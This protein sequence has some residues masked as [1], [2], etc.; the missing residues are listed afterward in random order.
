[1]YPVTPHQTSTTQQQV[2]RLC[3]DSSVARHH[4]LTAGRS[5]TAFCMCSS[6][7]SSVSSRFMPEALSMTTRTLHKDT[8][9]IKPCLLLIPQPRCVS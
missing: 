9:A 1:M 5:G 7:V 4:L 3:G 2:P 6:I 8:Q